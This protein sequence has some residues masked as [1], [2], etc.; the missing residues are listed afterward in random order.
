MRKTARAP[1]WINLAI[2]M[3]V[4]VSP[5]LLGFTESG[6]A[7]ANAVVTGL[8]ITMVAAAAVAR[9]SPTAAWGNLLLAIWLFASPWVVGYTEFRSASRN[10]W[11][12]A[13]MVA[14]F[15]FMT[16]VTASP[17]R[18]DRRSPLDTR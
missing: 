7:T 12:I 1:S 13:V 17:E 8:A 2:G 4:L 9:E 15:A 14:L 3:W 10:A 11:F 5:W 6:G 16:L 18:D